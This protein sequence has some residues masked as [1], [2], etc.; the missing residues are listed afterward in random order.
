L[1][2]AADLGDVLVVGLNSDASVRRQG[3]GDDRPIN[4]FDAR[5]LVIASLNFVDF[6]LL[7]DDDTPL[8]LIE[9][10]EPDVLVKG[11]DYDPLEEDRSSKKYIVGRDVV[12]GIGGRVETINLVDGF[13]TTSILNKLKDDN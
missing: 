8:K 11:G 9:L 6:V 5:A 2:K 3:K 13:S 10:V 1:A 4:D 12:L 7:F